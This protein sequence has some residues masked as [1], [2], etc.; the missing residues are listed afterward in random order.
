MC[1]GLLLQPPYC[2]ARRPW[3][4]GCPE[5]FSLSVMRKREELW[6]REWV[7][8]TM[9]L[10]GMRTSSIFNSRHVATCSRVAKRLQHVALNNVAFKC[11][12]RLVGACKCWANNVGICCAEILLLFGRGFRSE[13]MVIADCIF[14]FY[15]V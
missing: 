4:R 7:C 14:F 9:L 12:D 1:Q 2:K 3:G 10:L 8:P 15:T 6:G 5:L 13:S 11:C